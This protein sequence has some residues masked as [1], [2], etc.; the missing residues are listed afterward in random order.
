MARRRLGRL[1]SVAF[2]LEALGVCLVVV[3]ATAAYVVTRPAPLPKGEVEA[4][5][6]EWHGRDVVVTGMVRNLGS[7]DADF[8]VTPRFWVVGLGIRGIHQLAEVHVPAGQERAWV[9]VHRYIAPRRSGMR[10]GRCFPSARAVPRPG[11]GD[12]EAG[13]EGD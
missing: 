12:H 3:L 7:S 9:Y 2:S 8:E 4:A 5:S 11:H 10:I 13:V 1:R 6:C